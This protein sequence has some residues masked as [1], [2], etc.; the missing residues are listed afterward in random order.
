VSVGAGPA[1]TIFARISSSQ[2]AG[3]ASWNRCPSVRGSSG[4]AF[5]PSASKTACTAAAHSAVRSPRITPA[6]PNVVLTC[7][8]RS[9]NPSSPASGREARHR[10]SA[11]PAIIRR[12][13]SDA[14]A[15]AAC[16]RIVIVAARSSAGSFLVQRGT[17]VLDSTTDSI[18]IF[19]FIPQIV[20][21]CGAHAPS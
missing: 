11:T 1:G 19:N 10:S 15:A 5:F 12:S 21:W 6:P 13:S 2:P 7:T 3:S 20:V 16:T 9:S 8:Y 4:P 17:G 14:P 18:E